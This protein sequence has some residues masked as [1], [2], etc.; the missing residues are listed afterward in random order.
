MTNELEAVDGNLPER[1]SP[2]RI[3]ELDATTRRYVNELK[4]ADNTKRAFIQDWDRWSEFCTENNVHPLTVS[5]GLLVLFVQWLAAGDPETGRDPAA[6][7]TVIRRLSGV[8]A[9]W[10][11]NDQDVPHGIT[12]DARKMV[13]V[14]QRWLA[15]N[16]E[17]RGRGQA[18][19]LTMRQLR[20]ICAAC[21][22]TLAGHRDRALVLIGFGIGARRSELAR[23]AVN[24]I[25]EDTE[26]LVVRVRHSKVGAREAAIPHGQH[27]QTD[28]VRAW[29]TWRNQAGIS[30][31]EPAFQQ[32]DRHGNRLGAMSPQSVG[33]AI[34]RAGKRADVHVRLTGHSVRSG[35]ATEARRAGHDMLTIAKQGG[36]KPNSAELYRYTRIIDRWSDNALTGIGL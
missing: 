19:P 10:K 18:P 26:G 4:S 12:S 25:T 13:E 34:T 27:R 2:E 16:N 24:D 22:D 31:K 17:Q 14:Y 30:G 9:G 29:L 6:P 32:V 36:W 3:A 7:S 1:L 8:M 5:S 11:A 23:L 28:P 21:P 35:M 15:E 33:Q 20:Q